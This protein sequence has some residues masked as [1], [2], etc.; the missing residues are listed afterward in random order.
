[1]NVDT[2][3]KN[4]ISQASAA[5]ATVLP[6]P[7]DA[8]LSG[9]TQ[10]PGPTKLVR[11]EDIDWRIGET[12]F[13]QRAGTPVR[14]VARLVGF[15]RHVSVV[16]TA[17]QIDG[18]PVF[19]RDGDTLVV[20]AFTGRKAYAFTAS[21]LKSVH[22][23]H[24]YLHLSYPREVRCATVRRDARIAVS[25]A[26]S[27]KTADAGSDALLVLSDISLSG[28]SGIAARPFAEPGQTC[29]LAFHVEV[30]GQS[31]VMRPSAVVRSV[32]PP[33]QEGRVRH[34]FEFVELQ[35]DEKLGL[36]AFLHQATSERP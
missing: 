13:L 23:P 26:A 21:A 4:R 28:A 2:A 30:A 3:E 10:A 15:I 11:M 12:V 8:P 29:N 20:R 6:Q 16:V 33:D 24:P 35:P 1:M 5:G 34:G 18:S 14:H 31:I 19:Y 22:L 9:T 36:A 25:V 27:V 7:L 17:P 32:S